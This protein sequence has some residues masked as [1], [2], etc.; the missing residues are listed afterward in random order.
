VWWYRPRATG[1]PRS[2]LNP[3]HVERHRR[4]VRRHARALRRD[5]VLSG[6]LSF[7]DSRTA[8]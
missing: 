6:Q 3:E 5:G 1:R 4:A 8:P 2:Y 7:D